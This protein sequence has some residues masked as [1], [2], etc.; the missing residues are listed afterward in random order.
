MALKGYAVACD[1]CKLT[2]AKWV[3]ARPLA[4]LLVNRGGVSSEP[5]RGIRDTLPGYSRPFRI[6]DQGIL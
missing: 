2:G 1:C 4:V 3:A 5:G 6:P